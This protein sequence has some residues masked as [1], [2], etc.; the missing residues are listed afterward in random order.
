MIKNL[1]SLRKQIDQV[2]KQL[3][4]LLAKRNTIVKKVGSTKQTLGLQPLD[5]SRWQEVLSTRMLWGK[6][7]GLDPNFIKEIMEVVHQQSIE[8]E[9]EICHKQ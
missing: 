8:I 1:N 3:I 9:E 2:D 5:V 4:E 7:I 6:E